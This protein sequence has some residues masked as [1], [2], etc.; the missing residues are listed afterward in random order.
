MN[1]RKYGDDQNVKC[2]WYYLVD[3]LEWYLVVVPY[4]VLSRATRTSTS[5]ASA[6]RCSKEA[7]D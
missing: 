2:L 7:S 6:W 5:P 1:V 3:G 4:Y